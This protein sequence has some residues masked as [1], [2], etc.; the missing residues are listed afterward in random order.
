MEA[1]RSGDSSTGSC[2]GVLHLVHMAQGPAEQPA[3]L[4]P[5]LKKTLYQYADTPGGG[6]HLCPGSD[7][8]YRLGLCSPLLSDI[9]W[10]GPRQCQQVYADGYTLSGLPGNNTGGDQH[11]LSPLGTLFLD[12]WF[13]GSA[14]R[15]RS[16]HVVEV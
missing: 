8:A 5:Y 4:G 10:T 7:G 1:H 15:I 11:V 3:D 16:D 9:L 12:P 14:Y 6:R 13:W 2:A